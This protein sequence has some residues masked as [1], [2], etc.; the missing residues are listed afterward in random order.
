MGLLGTLFFD[1]V[2]GK[3]FGKGLAAMKQAAEQG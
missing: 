3:D 1:K 2:I